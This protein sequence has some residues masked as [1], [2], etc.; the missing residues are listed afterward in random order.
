MSQSSPKKTRVSTSKR[1]HVLYSLVGETKLHPAH[2]FDWDCTEIEHIYLFELSIYIYINSCRIK[3]TSSL[4]SYWRSTLAEA[5]LAIC[6]SF[7]KSAMRAEAA[8]CSAACLARSDMNMAH[9]MTAKKFFVHFKFL[10]VDSPQKNVCHLPSKT[11]QNFFMS[12]CSFSFSFLLLILLSSSAPPPTVKLASKLAAGFHP[13]T[14]SSEGVARPE[15]CYELASSLVIT[16]TKE[17]R[18]LAY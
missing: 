5:S 4:S 3:T 10:W 15:Q 17:F 1:P 2:P 16:G 8:S 11:R 12:A 18:G 7:S 13:I 9:I 14:T 6:S